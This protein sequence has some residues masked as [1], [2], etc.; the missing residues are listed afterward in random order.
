M[1]R[2]KRRDFV[3]FDAVTKAV[4]TRGMMVED[5]TQAIVRQLPDKWEDTRDMIIL[6]TALDLQSRYGPVTIIS[7]DRKL[8]S[9]QTLVSCVW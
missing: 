7:S 3:P 2:K 4:R 1:A 8:R 6:A 9:E 5:L